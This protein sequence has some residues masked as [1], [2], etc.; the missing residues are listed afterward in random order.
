MLETMRCK[1][2]NL[3]DN[4]YKDVEK[5]Y[6][7]EKVRRFL[8]GTI[9]KTTYNSIF[10]EM[11]ISDNSSLYWVVRHKDNNK[12][13]GLVSIDLHHDGISREISYQFLSEWWGLGYAEEVVKRIIKYAFEELKLQKLVAETQSAN[14]YSCKLLKKVGM[15]LE[16]SVHRF[17]A[18]QYIFSICCA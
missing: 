14:E 5:L 8:G 6:I 1:I 2:I 11:N 15:E 16:Q 12:F 4:D 10:S 18:E 17:G 9:D 3:Q 7:D 13:L